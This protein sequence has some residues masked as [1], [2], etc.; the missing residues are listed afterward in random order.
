MMGEFFFLAFYLQAARGLSPLDAGLSVVPFAVGQLA[1][2]SRS[3]RF[4]GRFGAHRVTA[5]GMTLM[6]SAYVFFVFAGAH[7]P[8][9]VLEVFLF[10]EGV[11]VAN[12]TPPTTATIM[13]SV[14]RER[15]GAGSAIGNTM[16]QVGGAMGVAVFGTILATLYR[17]HIVASLRSVAA[18]AR[19]PALLHT[20]SASISATQAYAGSAGAGVA[21]RLGAP[22]TASFIDAMHAVAFAAVVLAALGAGVALRWLPRRAPAIAAPPAPLAR[23]RRVE[24]PEPALR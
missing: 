24:D 14:P 13:A 22:A 7:T 5:V 4:V 3:P 8:T 6:A 1:F 15:A 23:E 16:R 17:S 19:D 18:L 11:G 21:A 9:W 2:A 10:I 12:V 20:V